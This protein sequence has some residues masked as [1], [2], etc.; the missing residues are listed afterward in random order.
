M[1]GSFSLLL[2]KFIGKKRSTSSG[3][4]QTKCIR[5][6]V[7]AIRC[8]YRKSVVQTIKFKQN[9]CSYSLFGLHTNCIRFV[10]SIFKYKYLESCANYCFL[11]NSVSLFVLQRQ[12]NIGIT[13]QCK[14]VPTSFLF[15]IRM[16][17]ACQYCYKNGFSSR[18]EVYTFHQ[19]LR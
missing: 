4:K 6:L 17:P 2:F 11:T 13:K 15:D 16:V 9:Y 19:L 12:F 5:V 8:A 3:P 18:V 7:K 10:E 14:M 1:I